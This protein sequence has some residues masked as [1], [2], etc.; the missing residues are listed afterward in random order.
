MDGDSQ[1]GE[2]KIGWSGSEGDGMGC[3]A[4]SA[5]KLGSEHVR[6]FDRLA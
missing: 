4:L 2:L 1:E 6:A 5:P 3:L